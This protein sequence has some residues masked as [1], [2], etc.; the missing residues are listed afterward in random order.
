MGLPSGTTT[1]G[2]LLSELFPGRGLFLG[3]PFD[4]AR[5]RLGRPAG[6]GPPHRLT[7]RVLEL[8]GLRLVQQLVQVH[9]QV[10]A[11]VAGKLH[12]LPGVVHHDRV[13][14]ADLDADVATHAAR[15][16]DVEPV[17]D[18]LALALP[19]RE[20]GIVLHGDRHA[21]HR[22][23]AGADLATGAERLPPLS[24][25]PPLIIIGRKAKG[26]R[27]CQQNAIIWSMRSRGSEPRSHMN[28]RMKA[29]VFTTIRGTCSAAPTSFPSGQFQPPRK[30]R[31]P[32]TEISTMFTNSATWNID[33]RMPQHSTNGPP[34]TSDSA[35]GM[36]NGCR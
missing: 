22:A 3:R 4:F 30:R 18:L 35:T 8:P 5:G 26:N 31:E 12:T 25:P 33:Q 19:L 16:V 23:V 9:H 24:P 2:L 28:I 27:I 10:A 20:E 1:L 32:S 29:D 14:V 15:V 6:V 36:S 21:V 13:E 11:V 17:D 7:E 34:T